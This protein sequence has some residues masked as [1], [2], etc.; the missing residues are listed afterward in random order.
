MIQNTS[1]SI[2]DQRTV[3]FSEI[4][5]NLIKNFLNFIFLIYK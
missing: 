5:K 2:L 1:G 4:E 3:L